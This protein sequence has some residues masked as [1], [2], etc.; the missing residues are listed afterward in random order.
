LK[1]RP[2]VSSDIDA[3]LAIQ[4]CCPEIAQW[5]AWDY[6]RVARGEM[7]GWVVE[8][9]GIVG[10]FVVA[11]R[12]GKDVEVLNLGV[13]V[14]HRRRG[15]GSLLLKSVAEWGKT[16]EAD[17]ALLEVR[18]SNLAAMHFYERHGFEAVGRRA[19][20]Y[21]APIEDALLLTAKL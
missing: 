14:N 18:E 15:M 11:R 5:S 19:K 7:A 1:I 13:T 4:S 16:F 10:G 6:E 3:V 17:K 2:F 12:I 20:Y 9:N 8:A 21:T